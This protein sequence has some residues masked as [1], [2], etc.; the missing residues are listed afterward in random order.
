[1]KKGNALYSITQNKC[2][3]CNEGDVFISKN[4]YNIGSLT[5]MHKICPSC[6]HKYEKEPGYF[7][8]AM[9][10]SYGLSVAVGVAIFV[11][12][13]VLASP[14]SIEVY[15]ISIGVGLV[16]F[17]PPIFRYS[18]LIWMNMFTKYQPNAIHKHQQ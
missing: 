14:L 1:M 18:R 6:G 16:F 4:P 10:V 12:L 11:A 5:K 7:F 15:M 17:T 3:E 13:Y 2:P 9:Y 8:G